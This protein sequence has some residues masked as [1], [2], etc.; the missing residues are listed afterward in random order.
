MGQ[1]TIETGSHVKIKFYQCST[2]DKGKF[3]LDYINENW[4]VAA[5]AMAVSVDA[6]MKEL[7]PFTR[8]IE[9]LAKGRH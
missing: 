5:T 7:I 4:I 2:S 1:N 6:L 3:S 8:V 9:L